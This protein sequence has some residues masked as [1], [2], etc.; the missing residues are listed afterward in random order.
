M[1]KTTFSLWKKT[2][3]K[4]VL[5]TISLLKKEY[6]DTIG[7]QISE[8]KTYK[9][10]GPEKLWYASYLREQNLIHKNII[11][12]ALNRKLIFKQLF[13]LGKAD[14]IQI[15]KMQAIILTAHEIG[16]GIIDWLRLKNIKLPFEPLS[17]EE[18]FIADEFGKSF[19]PS[20]T[21]I[22][23]SFLK[24]IISE[25]KKDSLPII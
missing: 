13:I 9:F 23:H 17:K 4:S 16:H 3:D 15:T 22:S 5:E 8:D 18:E 6:L 10:I 2:F 19:A 1:D 25:M 21:K 14:N 24:D 11:R 7:L 20:Y 12:F